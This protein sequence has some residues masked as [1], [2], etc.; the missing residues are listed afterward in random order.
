MT[1]IQSQISRISKQDPR[2]VL[3]NKIC[4]KDY[5][6]DEQCVTVSLPIKKNK[7]YIYRVYDHPTHPVA[8]IEV[9]VIDDF[10]RWYD[11]GGECDMY[12]SHTQD[13]HIYT[14]GINRLS[15]YDERYDMLNTIPR[16]EIYYDE[17]KE[18]DITFVYLSINQEKDYYL[19]YNHYEMQIQTFEYPDDDT[20]IQLEGHRVY[21]E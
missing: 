5:D 3:L 12:N 19:T 4:K 2:Y 7:E 21:I 17:E 16:K 18:T 20:I 13:E 14:F 10:D 1:R 11:A 8:T 6:Y 15:E 9:L